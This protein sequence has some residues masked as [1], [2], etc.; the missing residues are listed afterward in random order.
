MLR[1]LKA[2]SDPT[3]LR[4]LQ[5]LTG[6]QLTSAQIARR[7]R[8]RAQTVAHH[9]KVLRLAELVHIT[10]GDVRSEKRYSTRRGTIE[11]SFASLDGF[12]DQGKLPSAPDEQNA[13]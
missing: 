7:L 5:Y 3:R 4:I 8:L 12:L 10:M 13:T 1:T 11:H 2:L 6:E 9:L